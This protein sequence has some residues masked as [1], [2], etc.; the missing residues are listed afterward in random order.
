MQKFVTFRS[1]FINYEW[2]PLKIHLLTRLWLSRLKV[3]ASLFW[4]SKSCTSQCSTEKEQTQNTSS[5]VEH[6]RA[7][8][9]TVDHGQNIPRARSK[10]HLSTAETY[11]EHGRNVSRAR[12]K[13]N[14]STVFDILSTSTRDTFYV[15]ANFECSYLQK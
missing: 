13:H 2:A 10:H 4:R 5:T 3:L 15:Q 6:S 14:S 8:S 12:S 11:L 1:S 9:S 7:W